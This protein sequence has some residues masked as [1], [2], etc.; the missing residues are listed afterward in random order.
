[1]WV[2]PEA[3]QR[4]ELLKGASLGKAMALMAN[5]G[6]GWK[7]LPG[8]NTPAYHESSKITDKQCFITLGPG[9]IWS[10]QKLQLS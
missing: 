9:C 7:G 10:N 2:R 6:L 1:M 4:V 5:I 3:Y 8:I